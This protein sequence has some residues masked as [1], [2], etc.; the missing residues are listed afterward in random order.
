MRTSYSA[1]NTYK[2]CPLQY[3]FQ[4]VDKISSPK[5]I[6]AVFG[7]AVHSALNYM[8]ERNP[9]YPT[10]DEVINFF[11]DKWD[12]KMKKF[13]PNSEDERNKLFYD[14]GI[15]IIQKFYKKNQPWNFN[16][17]EMESFFDFEL[18]DPENQKKHNITGFID[19]IDKNENDDGDVFEIIDY[20]TGK[21]MPSQKDVDEDLQ[22]SIYHLALL[23]K[24][25][26][27]SLTKIKSSLYYLKHNEKL[28]AEHSSEKLEKTKQYILETIREI[29][30]KIENDEE[31]P[32]NT[33]P[34]CGWCG[35]QKMC[36]MYRH[37]YGSAALSGESNL[38]EGLSDLN[39]G[40][41][42]QEYVDL[43]ANNK[44]NNNRTAELKIL[45]EQFMDAEKV[46]RVFG[47]E[48][49]ITR[50]EQQRCS[51]DEE[52]VEEILK[53]AKCLEKCLSL[54]D[55]KLEKLLPSLPTEI[56]SK[57]LENKKTKKFS[58]LTVGKRKSGD[59][60][61]DEE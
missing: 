15:K 22:L 41:V 18:E 48:Q 27:L 7:S 13:D 29:E 44:E 17:M 52:K 57:I 53:E 51:Y 3:K 38:I 39:I 50:K 58:T 55:K 8:F 56:K 33:S 6:E 43:K 45:L 31:F 16:V 19:R 46:E 36:P 2:N 28:S 4:N 59:R 34:L 40:E 23:K 54:D 12:E 1:L 37:M 60:E 21:K 26:H 14:E 20:K 30:E 49:Y 11:R 5:G 9:L 32:P 24:W 25:P 61:E 10:V 47:E 35:Y 42:I